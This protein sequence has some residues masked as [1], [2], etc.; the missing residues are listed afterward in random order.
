VFFK[1]GV[2]IQ[3]LIPKMAAENVQIGRPFPPLLDWARISTGTFDEV[4]AFTR[5]LK[6]VMA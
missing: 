1:S 5:T 6:K 4:Q 2:S 3:E